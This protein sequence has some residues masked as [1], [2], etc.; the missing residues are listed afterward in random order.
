MST[1]EFPKINVSDKG[2]IPYLGQ[3]W[4][5]ELHEKLKQQY[6]ADG[7]PRR[8]AEVKSVM[9]DWLEMTFALAAPSLEVNGIPFVDAYHNDDFEPFDESLNRKLQLQQL[10]VEEM[11]LKVAERRKR[12]PEQVKMLLDDALRRQS[13]MADRVE[14][15]VEDPSQEGE[16]M[17][18]VDSLERADLVAQEY[19]N[20]IELL[21]GLRKTTISVSRIDEA[22]QILEDIFKKS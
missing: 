4:R 21:D 14:F 1:V 7:D 6:G 11:T 16:E 3:V 5:K 10:K 19:T 12:V 2:D 18:E 8:M 15:E 17:L 20:T 9:E 13:A 22:E